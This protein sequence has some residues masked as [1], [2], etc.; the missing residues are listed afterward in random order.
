MAEVF[1]AHRSGPK[2]FQKQLVIKRLLP[3]LTKSKTHVRL[4]LKEARLAA[5]IDHPNVAHVS[6]FGEV[7]GQYY[8]AMEHVDGMTLLEVLRV[9]G[10]LTPGMASRIVID[11]LDALQAIHDTKDLSGRAL[12][13]VHRDITPRNVMLTRGGTVK[14]IDFGIAISAHD[15]Q[16]IDAGTLR[17]MSPEQ[18]RGE[19]LDQRSDLYS[20]GLLL[21]LLLTERIDLF[22]DG[23]LMEA[24]G[25]PKM[26]WESVRCAVQQAP[27]ARFSSARSFQAKLES[28]MLSCGADGTKSHLAEFAG[29]VVPPMTFMGR[30]FSESLELSASAP[31]PKTVTQPSPAEAKDTDEMLS[32]DEP[33][34]SASFDEQPPP[35]VLT[36]GPLP[37]LDTVEQPPPQIS[38]RSRSGLRWL[39]ALALASLGS[40]LLVWKSAQTPELQAE[41]KPAPVNK[42]IAEIEV[43]AQPPPAERA[44]QETPPAVASPVRA[45]SIHASKH[46]SKHV[47]KQRRRRKRIRR[48]KKQRPVRRRAE[49]KPPVAKKPGFLSIN[50]HP[51][52]RVFVDGAPQGPTPIARLELS[53]GLH[54]LRMS[55][56]AQNIDKRFKIRIRPGRT[57]GLKKNFLKDQ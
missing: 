46:A 56:P 48:P 13:L 57:L 55:N 4:F 2:G 32:A 24:P 6:D 45:P 30:I 15:E 23:E 40:C 37:R 43:P 17:F 51:W 25:V 7:D 50:S 38:A 26:L 35:T 11:V 33:E 16:P 44:S 9:S 5:L 41:A 49:P 1:L 28:F 20:A 10:A 53:A 31:A 8:I 18:E 47:S 27:E 12:H 54:E 21:M 14:L 19:V 3:D 34:V 42:P 52:T 36:P 22:E 29:F 39:V